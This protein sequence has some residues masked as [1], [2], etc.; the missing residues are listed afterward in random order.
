MKIAV[1][2]VYYDKETSKFIQVREIP[3][4]MGRITT[5]SPCDYFN[6]SQTVISACNIRVTRKRLKAATLISRPKNHPDICTNKSR[7]EDFKPW[8][9]KTEEEIASDKKQ[10]ESE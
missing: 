2:Q 9:V 10:N 8:R 5:G 1:G 6:D 4:N 7:F 3:P